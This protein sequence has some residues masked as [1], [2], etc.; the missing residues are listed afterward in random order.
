MLYGLSNAPTSFQGYINKILTK[1]L[2][3]LVIVYLDNISVY[4]KD[5]G[6]PHINVVR[7]VPKQVRKHDL[8][9]NWKK[10]RFHQDEV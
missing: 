10:C 4:T 2:D 9:A 3:I 5:P 8:F 1:K 7:W 6:Q